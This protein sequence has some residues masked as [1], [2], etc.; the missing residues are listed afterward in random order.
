M[1]DWFLN[2]PLGLLRNLVSYCFNLIPK[3]LNRQ[4]NNISLVLLKHLVCYGPFKWKTD[5]NDL[6][7]EQNLFELVLVCLCWNKFKVNEIMSNIHR[8]YQIPHLEP[9]FHISFFRYQNS[10]FVRPMD[11]YTLM[12]ST[13]VYR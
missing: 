2:M 1:L 7:D 13:F 4:K 10:S 11:F 12:F 8:K 6:S 5:G 3:C 9:C